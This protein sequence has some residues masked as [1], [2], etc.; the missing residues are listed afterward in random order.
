MCETFAAFFT[1]KIR[2]VKAAI[3]A[4]LTG[5]EIDALRADGTFTGEQFC[6]A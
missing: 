1:N 6:D 2:A 5:C 4:R 3:A